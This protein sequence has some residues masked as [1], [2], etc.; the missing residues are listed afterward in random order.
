MAS[1]TDTN[2]LDLFQH[3]PLPTYIWK[4]SQDQ[5]I[6]ESFNKAA[7]DFSG[8]KMNQFIGKTVEELFTDIPPLIAAMVQCCT[9]KAPVIH[10]LEM[11]MRTTGEIKYL[12]CTWIWIDA[13]TLLYHVQDLTAMKDIAEKLEQK[14]IERTAEL[15]ATNEQLALAVNEIQEKKQFLNQVF[16][17]IQEGI[18]IL[19]PDMNVLKVNKT[20]EKLYDLQPTVSGNKCYRV[21]QKNRQEICDFCPALKSIKDKV[22]NKAI[23]HTEHGENQ[24][25]IWTEVFSFPILDAAAKVTGIIEFIR[26]ITARKTLENQLKNNEQ[27][28]RDL[29]DNQNDAIFLHQLRTEG[30]SLF[31][32]VNQKAIEHYGYSR[33]EFQQIG[34]ANITIVEDSKKHGDHTGRKKLLEQGRLVFEATHIKKNGEQFP[35]EISTTLVETDGEKYIMSV[36]RD[37]SDRKKAE[38]KSKD[39]EQFLVN[40]F[41]SIQD[42]VSNSRPP[43]KTS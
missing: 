13:S 26:D 30:F 2:Y 22:P 23:I 19:D 14:V 1:T 25:H 38:K 3:I 8:P 15:K 35:V 42:G 11:P 21:F 29:L 27:K 9:L 34:P 40:V 17:S 33:E 10:E 20:M 39:N 28:Y 18:C 37:I 6:L 4:I 12:K 36:V 7:L 24:T 41:N 31:H 16:D 43:H 32:E 5:I